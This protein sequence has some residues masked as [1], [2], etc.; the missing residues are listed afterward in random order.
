MSKI[1]PRFSGL[2]PLGSRPLRP[3]PMASKLST[4]VGGLTGSQAKIIEAETGVETRQEQ[5]MSEPTASPPPSPFWMRVDVFSLKD[6]QILVQWPEN[7]TAEDYDDIHQWFAIL[8]R[9]FE[10]SVRTKDDEPKPFTGAK[11]EVS[12]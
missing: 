5:A 11:S 8:I 3:R 12:I 2:N 9:K 4:P 1:T 10:R 7:L 6:G